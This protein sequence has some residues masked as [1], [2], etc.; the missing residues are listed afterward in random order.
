MPDP[1]DIHVDLGAGDGGFLRDR[2]KR[3]PD[4]C[5]LGVERLLGRA[6]KIA[7]RSWRADLRNVRVARIEVSYAVK[8]LFPPASVSSITILFPDPWPKRRHHGNRLIQPGFM[9]D[10]RRCLRP[11]GWLAIKTDDEPY[12]DHVRRVLEVCQGFKPW[13]VDVAELLPEKTDF[14]RD[15]EKEGRSFY[16]AALKAA[17]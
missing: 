12:F 10:C 13:D 5:F 11:D 7:R 3:L 2:A 15:F 16:F 6:R 9:E 17:V 4:T 8:W 14:E 1:L